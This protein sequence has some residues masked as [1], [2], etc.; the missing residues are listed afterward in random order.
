VPVF[1]VFTGLAPSSGCGV[2]TSVPSIRSTVGSDASAGGMSGGSEE[3]AANSCRASDVLTYVQGSYQ[4]AAAPTGACLGADGGEIWDEFYAA[5]LGSEKSPDD[6][7][8]FK[9][10]PANAACA[11][12]ILTPYTADQLGP[13][14][15]FG[16]FVGQNVAGCIEIADPSH[17]SCPKAVQALSDCEIAAC[18]ANCPVSDPTSLVARQQCAVQADATG[19]ASFFLMASAC[20]AAEADAGLASPCLNSGFLEFYDAVVPL[21]CGQPMDNT[22]AGGDAGP[23]DASSGLPA[24][25]SGQSDAGAD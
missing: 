8:A 11:A 25:D 16:E 5:C 10:I 15:S 12:C 23:S 7:T 4:P 21:F 6:C 18:Q 17:P 2:V 9:Q 1:V 13:I 20:Q 24:S 14:L 3:D 19:C 22:D